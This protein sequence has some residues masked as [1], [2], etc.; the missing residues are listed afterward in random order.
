MLGILE[1]N[2]GLQ[3]TPEYMFQGIKGYTEKNIPHGQ[4]F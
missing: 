3:D 1:R 2:L 4:I